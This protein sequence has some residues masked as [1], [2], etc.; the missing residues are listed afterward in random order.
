MEKF[1]EKYRWTA[2]G[3]AAP[4]D[5]VITVETNGE[6]VQLVRYDPQRKRRTVLLSEEVD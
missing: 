3:V 6:V 2:Q 4:E 5:Y 1:K